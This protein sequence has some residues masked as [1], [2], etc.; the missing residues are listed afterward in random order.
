MKESVKNAK[1]K[2]GSLLPDILSTHSNK[3]K[4]RMLSDEEPSA[5]SDTSDT[6]R[7][8]SLA[9]RLSEQ[10]AELESESQRGRKGRSD[11]EAGDAA[12]SVKRSESARWAR[13]GHCDV[14]GAP[15]LA[16]FKHRRKSSFRA[17][18]QL[19]PMAS[20][21][22]LEERERSEEEPFERRTGGRVVAKVFRSALL[23][24]LNP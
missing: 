2:Y 9:S 18:G 12:A 1:A 15:L 20:V 21:S 11:G 14:D 6:S 13:E 19:N 3:R 5:N 16:A 4:S 22:E 24:N 23:E 8:A 17:R 10:G 7:S